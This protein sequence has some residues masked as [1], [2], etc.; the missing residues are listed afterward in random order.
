MMALYIYK[1]GKVGKQMHV[2]F[3][4]CSYV[5][6]NVTFPFRNI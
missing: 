3:F 4:N 1:I 2:F 6:T 5:K